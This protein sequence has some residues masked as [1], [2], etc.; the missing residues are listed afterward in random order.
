MRGRTTH[1]VRRDAEVR[2]VCGGRTGGRPGNRGWVGAWTEGSCRGGRV[3][4]GQGRGRKTGRWTMHRRRVRGRM[5]LGGSMDRG[6]VVGTWREATWPAPGSRT[7]LPQSER[8]VWAFPKPRRTRAPVWA[9]G[10]PGRKRSEAHPD[11]L[12]SNTGCLR[13]QVRPGKKTAGTKWRTSHLC[14]SGL[15]GTMKKTKTV[16]KSPRALSLRDRPILDS[17]PGCVS[18]G[19][20]GPRRART[21]RGLGRFPGCASQAEVTDTWQS[22]GSPLTLSLG[23]SGR[24]L[25]GR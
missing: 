5:T 16:S 6:R 7:P 14:K 12:R 2:R 1:G 9:P 11:N 13:G 19:P 24:R 18:P 25:R 23:P 22:S 3:D 8:S 15:S 20:G 17:T 10:H 4:K 21:P